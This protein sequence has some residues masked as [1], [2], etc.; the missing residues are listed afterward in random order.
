MLYILT[1]GKIAFTNGG[2]TEEVNEEFDK[3]ECVVLICSA[4]GG[5]KVN[6][7]I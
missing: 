7:K 3:I 5:M 4:L 2:V 6:E 1:A